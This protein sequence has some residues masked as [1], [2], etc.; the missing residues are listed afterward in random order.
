MPRALLVLLVTIAACGGSAKKDTLP[1]PPIV[2]ADDLADAKSGA[3]KADPS[4][5]SLTAKDPRVVDLDIIKIRASG[6]PGSDTMT[7]VAS[8]DLFRMANEAAKEGRTESAI[9]QYRQLIH[10]FPD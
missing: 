10:E 8:A 6:P 3:P 2:P 9:Q 1:S 7:S 5:S 4:D